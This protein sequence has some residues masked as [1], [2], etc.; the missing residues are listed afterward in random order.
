MGIVNWI[1]DR[2]DPNLP[3]RAESSCDGE[4]DPWEDREKY[5][6]EKRASEAAAEREARMERLNEAELQKRERDAGL[7]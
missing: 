2:L 4:V 6:E 5:L 1:L 7:R 3:G